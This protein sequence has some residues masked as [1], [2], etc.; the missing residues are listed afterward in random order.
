MLRLGADEIAERRIHART[1]G[2]DDDDVPRLRHVERGVHHEV[3][4]GVHLDR[5]G[6]ADDLA[7][8]PGEA[9]DGGS[10]R[11]EAVELV[12]NVGRVE[13]HELARELRLEALE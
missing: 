11:R 8:G 4:G 5:T 9:A 3:V 13:R 1:A 2:V 7:P 12:R 6:R 10:Q